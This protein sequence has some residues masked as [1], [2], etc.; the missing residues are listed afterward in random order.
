MVERC[1]GVPFRATGRAL[2][3]AGWLAV[4]SADAEEKDEEEG[5]G[6]RIPE[7]CEGE[8]L[9]LLELKPEQHFTKPPA[10]YT[11]ATLVKALEE[12]GIGRPSTYAPTV[13]IIVKRGYV[14]LKGKQLV[15]TPLGILVCDRLVQFFPDLLSVDFTA[16][17][18]D[19]LDEVEEGK[20]DW[21]EAVRHFYEPFKEALEHAKKRMSKEGGLETDQKCSALRRFNDCQVLRLR[22]LPCL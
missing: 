4:Y 9:R 7:L 17:M 1:A 2:K 6:V 18:E 8:I 15:P 22:S 10:R 5:E 12:L 21:Q 14:E 16:Q 3:F 11:Q 19:R 13:D 20:G